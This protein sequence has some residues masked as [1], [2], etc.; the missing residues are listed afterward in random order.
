MR[1]P[2]GLARLRSWIQFLTSA[3]GATFFTLLIVHDDV[4]RAPQWLIQP[5]FWIMS[6]GV[7]TLLGFAFLDWRQRRRA[8]T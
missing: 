2:A 5:A 6:I 7:L 4:D 1:T 3:A 8:N